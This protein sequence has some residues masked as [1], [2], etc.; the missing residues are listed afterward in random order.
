M[1]GTEIALRRLLAHIAL[2]NQVARAR[3]SGG[4]RGAH[5]AAAAAAQ[6]PGG[7]GPGEIERFLTS[8]RPTIA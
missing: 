7:P 5:H 8:R 2:L 3:Q 1:E 4:G 6:G